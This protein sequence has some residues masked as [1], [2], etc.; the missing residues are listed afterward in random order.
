MNRSTGRLR[1]IRRL[2]AVSALFVSL[3]LIT[4]AQAGVSIA[5]GENG[6]GAPAP[7]APRVSQASLGFTDVGDSSLAFATAAI[8]YVAVTNQWMADFGTDKFRPT[9]PESR[10]LFARAIVEAFAPEEPIDPAITFSDLD[11]TDP[12]FPYA[13]VAVKMGW[14]QR[15]KAGV[16]GP[17]SPVTMQVVHFALVSALPLEEEVAGLDAIHTEAGYNFAHPGKFPHILLGM[18]LHFRY[19]HPSEGADVT[20][21]DP[22]SR[23]EVAYSLWRAATTDK[24]DIVALSKYADIA[25]PAISASKQKFVAFGLKYVGYPYI[26]GGDWYAK[27]PSGYCCGAQPKGGFDCSGLMWWDLK[28]PAD[29]YNNRSLRGYTGWSIPQR[30]SADMASIGKKIT[31]DNAQPGDLMFYDGDG[32]GT[33]DHVDVFLGNGWALDSSSGQGGVTILR[34]GEGWY[35]DHFVHARSIMNG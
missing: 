26:W 11:E 19:N 5:G 29:G 35:N 8:K 33:V 12:F 17:E 30:A 1:P 32:N 3:A 18:V 20:P 6:S 28:A 34:V 24:Y 4:P 21:K 9:I 15:T 2:A 23:V 13:N 16:F 22:L 14:M 31:Y 7:A 10:A 25:L 27:T